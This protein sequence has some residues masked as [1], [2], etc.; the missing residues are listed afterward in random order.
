MNFFKTSLIAT[1]LVAAGASSSAHAATDTTTFQVRIVISEACDIQT[2]GATDVDFSSRVRSTG[3]PVD[4]QGALTVNCSNGTPYTIG[5]NAGG[6]STS[7]T[8]AADNRRMLGG[9]GNFVPYGLYRDAGRTLFW[10]DLIGTNTLAGTG[11]ASNQSIPVYGRVPST[12]APA[13]SYAD[14]V[15]AT[16]TY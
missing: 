15:T 16:I 14:T 6:S 10:G 3:A 12:N 4:A 1:A 2:V 11:N 8:A 9:A 13:G 7:A 5:L